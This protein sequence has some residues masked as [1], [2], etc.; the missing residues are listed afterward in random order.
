MP[1]PRFDVCVVGSGPGGGIASYVLAKHGLKVGLIEAGPRLRPGADYNAHGPYFQHLDARLAKGRSP[2][3]RVTEF[4]ER[5]HYTGVG[6]RPNHG[7]LRALGG[8]SLCWA[9]HSLRFGPLDFRRWSALKYEDVA[10]YYSQAER[11]MCVSGYKDGLSNLPDG[12][13]LPG[14][15]MRC[16]ERM[17]WRGVQRLKSKGRAMEYVA[18]RK[19]IPTVAGKGRVP[20][21][22][23]G[24]CMAGCEVDSKYTSAN[25]PIPLGLKTGNLTVHTGTTMTR[26]RM[27]DGGRVSGITC[28]D[29]SGREV[30]FDCTALVLACSTIETAR[31][32][33]LNGIA[34]SS[35]QVGRNLSSHFG[36]SVSCTFPEIRNR[37]ASNDDGT[38]YYHS[39]LT[40][41]YWD[42]PG[43]NFEGTYQ[44]QC[45]SGLQSM[46]LPIRDLPGYGA[47]FKKRL[48]EINVTHANMN[49]Q[50]SL[51]R[52]SRNYVD[53]DPEKK[54]RF[55]LPLPRIHLHYSDSDV[56][57]ANDMVQT[58]EDV[59]ASAGGKVLVSPGKVTAANLQIDYNHWVGT[60]VMG[61]DPKAS[62]L[63]PDGQSHDVKNLFVGDSSVFDWNPE[64]NPTLT[65][66]ALSWR[67]SDRLAEKF[68][69]G[70]LQA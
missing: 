64:K 25:T 55:G 35:G 29:E 21:H 1:N 26:I 27:A 2:Y 61:K 44:V 22:Y 49:M 62:V 3:F 67:M 52:T 66:I 39:L 19:A 16:A 57:M 38:D 10:P 45:A 63:N 47:D 13:F 23:C 68:R 59:I 42:Q 31:H 28:V 14:V 41:L 7:F 58:C 9:G 40:G 12:D 30:Q 48:R 53:L 24:H 70:E 54:D 20:C 6:D 43:K 18:Q 17:L 11:L 4:Q 15:P 33:L 56:A 46:R 5:N 36:L 51:L 34:N 69:K 32:L 65:N 50:G 60:V 8:R 37:D